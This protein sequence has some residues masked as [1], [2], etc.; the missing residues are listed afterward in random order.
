MAHRN[1]LEELER[2]S[3]SLSRAEDI[4]LL[5]IQTIIRLRA[6]IDDRIDYLQKEAHRG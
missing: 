5:R 4:L 3:K 2:Q 1:E 6:D